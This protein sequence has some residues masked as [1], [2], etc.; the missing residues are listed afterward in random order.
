[1]SSYLGR[2]IEQVDNI[3]K[4]D[5]LTFN[6]GTTYA[7]TKDSSAFTPISSNAILISVSGVIQ[8][9]N[10][11]VSGS[12]IVFDSAVASSESCDFIMHYGTGVAFTPA[13]NSITDTKLNSNSVTTAKIQNDAVTKDKVDFVTDSGG[14]SLEAK[15]SSGYDGA[16][17]LNCSVNSHYT[18][19]KSSPH[20]SY[21]GNLNFVLP[22]SHGT[23]GQFL[24]TN[25]SGGLS[26]ADAGGGLVPITTVAFS[27]GTELVINNCFSSTYL[28][29][30][31]I[32]SLLVPQSD[33]SLNYRFNV[34]GTVDSSSSYRYTLEGY[35]NGGSG[36]SNYSNGTTDEGRLFYDID[37]DTEAGA[38]GVF[39][40]HNPYGAFQRKQIHGNTMLQKGTSGNTTMYQVATD[41]HNGTTQNFTGINLF[42]SGATNWRAGSTTSGYGRVS[43]FGIV[44]S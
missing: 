14:A 18:E 24:K 41:Y 19:L 32:I 10:F 4:L 12:N 25:G 36:T 35:Q 29:Y 26:F 2:G 7:L 23:N 34:G 39:Y 5:N 40:I 13:D 20:G 15:G 42:S 31:M 43:I 9:G 17:R 22:S 33:A 8:Q 38:S 30:M 16:I 27:S 37:A 3:S 21:S 1:M 28:N 6:G 11:S 44:N